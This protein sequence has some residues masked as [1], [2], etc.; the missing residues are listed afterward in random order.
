MPQGARRVGPQQ[1]CV[2]SGK[3]ITPGK[4]PTPSCIH[5]Q[6]HSLDVNDAR[7]P[8]TYTQKG[9]WAMS[10]EGTPPLTSTIHASSHIHI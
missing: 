3:L 6:T 5:Q 8:S 10:T 1:S 7:R 4:T 9:T 2:L